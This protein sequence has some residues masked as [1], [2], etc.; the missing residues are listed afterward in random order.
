MKDDS[1]ELK[2]AQRVQIYNYYQSLKQ[3]FEITG[4][5]RDRSMTSRAQKARSKL[6]KLSAPQFFE[7][8]TDVNDELQ[9]R[10]DESQLQ[11][12]FLAPN[13]SFHAKR[14]QARQ[15]LANLSNVRFNDLVDDILFEIRRRGFSTLP[16]P[17][18]VDNEKSPNLD[19][20]S[21]PVDKAEQ[22]T[23][24]LDVLDIKNSPMLPSNDEHKEKKEK[25]T[26]DDTS[27]LNT[28]LQTSTVIPKTASIDWSSDEE[29]P[30]EENETESLEPIEPLE[31]FKQKEAKE[32]DV[33]EEI[34]EKKEYPAQEDVSPSNN[35]ITLDDV[36]SLNQSPNLEKGYTRN[37]TEQSNIS[38]PSPVGNK[39]INSLDN[40]LTFSDR[41]LSQSS[42]TMTPII[43]TAATTA[44]ATG[45]GL[46]SVESKSKRMGSLSQSV[47]RNKDRDIEL[48]LSEGNKLDNVITNLEKEKLQ[49]LER[50]K[51]L[52]SN[53][54]ELKAKN[55]SLCEEVD[56]LK[57]RSN[58]PSATKALDN[59]FQKG[60]S[61]LTS[62]LNQLSVEN[63]ELKQQKVELQ[64]LLKNVSSPTKHNG[65]LID[66]EST[67]NSKRDDSS[68]SRSSRVAT[69]KLAPIANKELF[70]ENSI[71][72]SNLID[73]LD[74]QIA[75]ILNLVLSPQAS[76]LPL[77]Q[78]IASI[79]DYCSK[80]LTLVNSSDTKSVCLVLE[81]TISHAITSVRYYCSYKTPLL[82]VILENSIAEISYAIYDLIKTV[83]LN[84]NKQEVYETP[85]LSD[86][87]E[88]SVVYSNQNTPMQKNLPQAEDLDY[89]LD[90]PT[91]SSA[92]EGVEMSPVK[93]LKIT[94][95]R[96]SQEAP[97]RP[98]TSRKPSGPGLFTAMLNGGLKKDITPKSSRNPLHLELQL[99]GSPKEKPQ[100][101]VIE[102]RGIKRID[103]NQP[104]P[105]PERSSNQS[106]LIDSK[107]KVTSD[108]TATPLPVDHKES[109]SVV[110]QPVTSEKKDTITKPVPSVERSANKSSP[111]DTQSKPVKQNSSTESSNETKSTTSSD[112]KSS[113]VTPIIANSDNVVPNVTRNLNVTKSSNTERS[114]HLQNINSDMYNS[115]DEETGGESIDDDDTN[116]TYE[117]LRKTMKLKHSQPEEQGKGSKKDIFSPVIHPQP[118]EVTMSDDDLNEK[119]F[120]FETDSIEKPDSASIPSSTSNEK[121]DNHIPKLV[122]TPVQK[123]PVASLSPAQ[124]VVSPLKPVARD[125]IIFENA[126][127]NDV[128]RGIDMEKASAPPSSIAETIEK[129]ESEEEIEF[130]VDAF[131]IENPDNSL[132]DLLLYLEYQTMDVINTI[133][134]LLSSI[135]QPNST[136]GEL[137]TESNAINQVIRQMVEATSVSMN[138]SRNSHLKEH[139]SWVVQSLD[140]C[141]RRM[142]V[143]C[144]LKPDG[145]IKSYEGDEEFADKHFKQRLAGIAFD[146]A[147]CTKEL[148]KTVEEASLKTNID[149]LNAKLSKE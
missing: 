117:A 103:I 70:P 147:K 123:S 132:A 83:N 126:K 113:P 51:K 141:R 18:E 47:E 115:N 119:P 29:E 31:P 42:A 130:D 67:W 54:E 79:S 68:Q 96:S 5:S 6:L 60:M 65:S 89:G 73:D 62:H 45:F 136:A 82:K 125:S 94:Q 129:S 111:N 139:G 142:T 107:S 40:P 15:K 50:I 2:Y 49:L 23:P 46:S 72:P 3:F 39:S 4:G 75:N 35:V 98:V 86:E 106:N 92:A 124:L 66:K 27:P 58:E 110:Q 81:N 44:A 122:S 12:E 22:P 144:H 143:L 11:H 32:T 55:D 64:L 137:R 76:V 146:V 95:K 78:S 57:Q 90:K 26:D 61:E 112:E 131:D 134:S 56:E 84:S 9:R 140:D 149:Y 128:K 28:T 1:K 88:D 85:K 59:N 135:K 53:N 133:Q 21:L 91:F 24:A 38:A 74:S 118:I 7:L 14:N 48:L 87:L 148:V 20:G 34:N 114:P 108:K 37:P 105:T 97:T 69:N 25:P 93:P 17:E 41:P 104:S 101:P 71:I 127:A 19:N 52:E 145:E 99:D 10:I 80:I 16:A 120:N 109:I 116:A 33:S 36:S 30:K 77:F 43:Q 13:E 63:E 8:S 138:Q 100:V 121:A 102:T